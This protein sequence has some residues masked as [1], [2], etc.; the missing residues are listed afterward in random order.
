MAEP[1]SE[2]RWQQ[3]PQLRRGQLAPEPL[4]ADLTSGA[5][6]PEADLLAALWGRLDRPAVQSLLGSV[7]AL[8]PEPW[9]QASRHELPSL[10]SH[11]TVE[12]AWL[13]PLLEHQQ[14]APA[15]HQL[16]WLEVLGHFQDP[17]V[18]QRLR[19]VVLETSRSATGQPD[20]NI[21]GTLE[22]VMPL[23]P[24]LGRQRQRQDGVLLLQCCLDP[25]PLAW[26]QAALD[27]VALGLSSWPLALLTPALRRLAGDLSP[28]MAGQAIDLLARLPDGQRHLRELLSQELDPSVRE[29]LRR[30]RRT[31]PVLLLIHG[32]QG[33]TIPALY[34]QLARDL[35]DR[36][37]SPVLL[38]ALTGET[39]QADQRV[40]RAAAQ[41]GGLTLV[42]LLLLP[43]EH[44]R[45]DLPVITTSWRTALAANTPQAPD[46][47]LRRMPFLGAWPAWQRLLAKELKQLASGRP[48]IWLHHPLQGPLA[49]RYLRHLERVL[50]A[51]GRPADDPG[52]AISSDGRLDAPRLL[53]PLSLA[54]SRISESLRMAGSAP[55]LEVLPPLL[56]RT[57]VRECLLSQLEALP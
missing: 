47:N 21:A 22:T 34:D 29:R 48:W 41:N 19:R 38:Q 54:P 44:V 25:G 17:R 32:R 9:R 49:S 40:W 12:A 35:E 11:P 2:R 45:H 14:Q 13:E 31:T 50:A 52:S 5:L 53:V 36:R 37:R 39:P 15:N 16:T 57:A 55:S 20:R 43:G 26:R 24:L 1:G 10:A 23:L 27:G 3:L 30:R 56:E 33:G 46:V 42:P 18:A 7:A 4:I 6:S 51:E 28:A 8:D